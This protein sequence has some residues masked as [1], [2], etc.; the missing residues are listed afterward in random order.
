[1]GARLDLVGKQFGDWVVVAREGM[2]VTRWRHH[3]TWKCACTV[4]GCVRTIVGTQLTCR[5]STRC[6]ECRKGKTLK[7]VPAGY[8]S[9]LGRYKLNAKQR[10]IEWKLSDEQAKILFES[11]CIY[12]ESEP[13]QV[14]APYP[15]NRGHIYDAGKYVYTGIDRIDSDG[16]YTCDNCV[17][18]C[19][20]CN[21]AKGESSLAEF[22]E[23]LSRVRNEWN[24]TSK[25]SLG[26][27]G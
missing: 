1:M 20:R 9:L 26:V 4:C 22:K 5:H 12:C 2:R 3:T 14:H 13:S 7:T 11:N 16:N 19:G 8:R 6:P 17:P 10:N 15:R 18:C 23:W 24:G 25:I 21:M 27:C